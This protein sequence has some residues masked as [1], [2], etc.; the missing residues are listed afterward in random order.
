MEVARETTNVAA[1]LASAKMANALGSKGT[2]RATIIKTV[3]AVSAAPTACGIPTPSKET[4][5]QKSNAILLTNKGNWCLGRLQNCPLR[6]LASVLWI[7]AP[8]KTSTA[9]LW[10]SI[11]SAVL[12][13]PIMAS[14][15]LIN[16]ATVAQN[17]K[18][19]AADARHQDI[20][21]LECVVPHGGALSTGTLFLTLAQPP[22]CLPFDPKLIPRLSL[23]PMSTPATICPADRVPL[24]MDVFG[25]GKNVTTPQFLAITLVVPTPHN[26]AP[27]HQWFQCQ[28]VP[29][30]T[31]KTV[32]VLL[33]VLGLVSFATTPSLLAPPLAVPT[34]LLSVEDAS[35]IVSAPSA[36]VAARELV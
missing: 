27:S 9:L 33:D 19:P 6:Q 15:L 10:I 14:V 3:E 29:L 36:T 21:Y 2:K 7:N 32:L 34:F 25:L 30:T 16:T 13:A 26:S 28:L 35:W 20:Q 12:A 5:N 22:L 11:T 23:C 8:A 31:A 4:A 17:A 18:E 1:R 24:L